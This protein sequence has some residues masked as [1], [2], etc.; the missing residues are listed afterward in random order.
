MPGPFRNISGWGN[1]DRPSEL[2]R[3]RLTIAYP[4]DHVPPRAP[5]NYLPL[6]VAARELDHRQ[7]SPPGVVGS[8]SPEETGY[9]SVANNRIDFIIA[10]RSCCPDLIAR[11]MMALWAV[12]HGL[13]LHDLLQ[14][15]ESTHLDLADP[16]AG[17]II[18]L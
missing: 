6:E 14:F 13:R 7:S 12:L 9:L 18:L 4:I 5:Q 11:D 15:F 2:S 1:N 17:D 16:L 3:N 10:Y 8:G